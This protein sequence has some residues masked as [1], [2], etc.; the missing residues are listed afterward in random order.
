MGSAAA[1]RWPR[2]ASSPPRVREF[3]ALTSNSQ[4]S[5]NRNMQNPISRTAYY[6]LAVRNWDAAQP[7]PM[8]GDSLARSF[9][10]PEAEGVWQQFKRYHRANASNA[11]RHAIIDEHLSTVLEAR[12]Q[13]RVIIIGAGFDTRAFRLKGG[14][15]I[16]VDVNRR[17]SPTRNRGCRL[18][19]HRTGSSACRSRSHANPW[20]SGWR[21][22]P[23]RN[24][25]T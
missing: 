3:E 18:L 2:V 23:A 10:N 8:C 1:N 17:F 5:H 25:L 20:R 13:A 19:A 21:R 12:P 4:R 11:A 22:L 16:E 14:R 24:L 6:T 9:M 15:W 7:R